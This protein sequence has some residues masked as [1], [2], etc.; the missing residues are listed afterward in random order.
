MTRV[1]TSDIAS[2]RSRSPSTKSV[3][4]QNHS[5]RVA[6]ET[7]GPADAPAVVV[8]GGISASRHV[9]ATESDPR[10]GWW[11][12]FVGPEK[13][14]DTNR[15]RVVGVDYLSAG[16]RNRLLS[17]HDQAL[18]LA[19]ALDRAAIPKVRA[20]VGASYGGMVALAFG[21]IA[22]QRVEHLVVIGAAHESAP[23]AT[24]LRILQRRIVELGIATGRSRD[25]LV[26]ARGLAM[27]S[28]GSADEFSDRF[29]GSGDGATS[30][31]YE[32]INAFLTGSGETFATGCSPERFLA[33]SQSLDLHK[34]SPEDVRVPATLIAV[35]EDSLVPLAQMRELAA[36]I[37]APCSLVEISSRH[38]HDTFL[39]APAL[40]APFVARS[41]EPRAGIR[42]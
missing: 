18:A 32:E 21:A 5:R 31:K 7:V 33:L 20:I 9:T 28:Y 29:G 39:N 17:T 38:G 27:T 6:F 19:S 41:L 1:Q 13:V 11:E 40:L 12:D 24:A 10:R 4:F 2:P 23:L 42:S 15:F 14:V 25:A 3:G 34:V 26:I 16:G 22:P 37:G 35:L 30:D 36:R 8:L